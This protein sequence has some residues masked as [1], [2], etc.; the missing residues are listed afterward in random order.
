VVDANPPAEAA[1]AGEG[2]VG[3]LA[4]P[5]VERAGTVATK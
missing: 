3:Y 1:D 5:S 4:T 2:G